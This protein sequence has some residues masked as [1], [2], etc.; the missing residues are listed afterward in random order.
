MRKKLDHSLEAYILFFLS[1]LEARQSTKE[2]Y[3]RS[4][5]EFRKYVELNNLSLN[6]KA[7]LNWK[8]ELR[9]KLSPYTINVYLTAVRQFSAFIVD[10]QNEIIKDRTPE[11]TALIL[12]ELN[13]IGSVKNLKIDTE[14]LIK[15]I[16][17]KEEIRT[18]LSPANKKTGLIIALLYFCG[19]RTI[20]VVRLDLKDIDLKNNVLHI[21][22]KG[23]DTKALVQINDQLKALLGAYL[24]DKT[25]GALFPNLTTSQ[26]RKNVNALLDKLDLKV[27]EKKRSCHSF[28]HSFCVHLIEAGIPLHQVQTLARHKSITTTEG[29]IKKLK[30]ATMRKEGITNILSL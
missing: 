4:L 28:R 3:K 27:G 23:R 11:E 6:R 5:N 20:E 18:L 12:K 13:R 2:T 25:S 14:E 29:Y 15:D 24:E 9:V 8:E 26:I 30:S 21:L 22:G 1:E 16:F 10:R 17:T 7:V 19:L